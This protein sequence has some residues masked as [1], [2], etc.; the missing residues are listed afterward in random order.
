MKKNLESDA[1]SD[2]KLVDK[3]DYSVEEDPITGV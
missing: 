2:L 3:V 1:E